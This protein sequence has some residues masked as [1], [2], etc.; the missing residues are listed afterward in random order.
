MTD[1]EI[2]ELSHPSQETIDIVNKLM[3]LSYELAMER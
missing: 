1:S 2:Y 3:K